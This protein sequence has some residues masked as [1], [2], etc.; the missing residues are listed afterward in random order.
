MC[1][2]PLV[3]A[4]NVTSHTNCAKLLPGATLL[5]LHQ[6]EKMEGTESQSN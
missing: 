6:Q 4:L 5:C 3:K 1:P 2:D